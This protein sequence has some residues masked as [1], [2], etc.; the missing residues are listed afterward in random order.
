MTDRPRIHRTRSTGGQRAAGPNSLMID[1]ILGLWR[2][3]SV[4]DASEQAKR[5]RG[6]TERLN[7]K[8]ESSGFK[9]IDRTG[10]FYD[11]GMPLK[12]L[13]STERE[14]IE[15]PIILETMAP[16]I[17]FRGELVRAGEVVIGIP[18]SAEQRDDVK[19]DAA[20]DEGNKDEQ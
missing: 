10:E 4:L 2:I 19:N 6:I 15:R 18:P 16:T 7:T 9:V 11:A 8:L 1:L 12:V 20:N 5:I 17:L 3:E 14:D 13:T